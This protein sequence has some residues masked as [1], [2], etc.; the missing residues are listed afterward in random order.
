MSMTREETER[1]IAERLYNAIGT[2]TFPFDGQMQIE[3]LGWLAVAREAMRM[4][5]RVVM[6]DRTGGAAAGPPG[7]PIDFSPALDEKP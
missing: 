7:N 6:E 4:M 1:A 5:E 2:G 3:Q